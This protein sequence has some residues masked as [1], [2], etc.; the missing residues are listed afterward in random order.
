MIEFRVDPDRIDNGY[1]LDFFIRLIK[2]AG[3]SAF[4]TSELAGNFHGTPFTCK[5]SILPD[6]MSKMI[7]SLERD[8]IYLIHKIVPVI[9]SVSE[10]T[11]LIITNKILMADIPLNIGEIDDR[12]KTG[13][14]KANY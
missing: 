8:K 7:S 9:G 14:H 10:H 6:T 5:S 11:D 13:D 2:R 1:T 12:A 3:L 4:Y